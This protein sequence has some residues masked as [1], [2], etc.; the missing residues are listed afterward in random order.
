MVIPKFE[1]VYE[2]DFYLACQEEGLPTPETQYKFLEK[3]KFRADFA[4]VAQRVLVE[5][6]GGEW[7]RGRHVRGSGFNSD[8][9]KQNLA[10]LAGWQ[11]FVFTGSMI[12]A[13]A[14]GCARLVKEALEL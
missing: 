1:S 4:W 5:I 2:R 10:V 3:R 14:C 9:E 11:P 6:H 8:C 7:A 13:D 12:T